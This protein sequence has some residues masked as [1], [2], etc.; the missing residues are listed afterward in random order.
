MRTLLI[1]PYF[2][3]PRIDA[4]DI[5]C[6]PMGLYQVAAALKARGHEVEVLNWHDRGGAQAAAERELREKRPQVV[7]CSILHANRWGGIEIAR[8]AK[9]IDP[10]VTVV[11]GGVGATFLWRH[12]LRHFPEIDYIV[13]GEGEESF[14]RLLAALGPNAGEDPGA[15][16]GLALRRRGRPVRTAAAEPVRDLDRLPMAARDFDLS[17]VA[18]TRGCASNC[19]FCGSPAVWGRRVRSHSAAYFVEQLARLRARG[20][21]F[22][23]V[24]DDTFT[25][26]RRR[27]LEV[28]RELAARRLELSWAAISRVDAVDEEVLGW[29][30]RAGCIQISYGVE[31]GSPQIRRRLNKRLRDAEIRTAF[32]WTQRYGIMARAYFI[33]GSPGETRETIQA[34]IDLMRAI[35]PLA[36][37]FYILDLF[38]G[39]ALYAAV[40]R[41]LGWTDDIWLRRVEDIPYFETDPS[42]PAE[43]VLEF[44]R[45]LRESFYRGLPGFVEALDPVADPEFRPLHADFFSR[46]ALTFDQGDYAGVDL[47]PG[48]PRLAEGLYRRAL[49]CHPHARAFLGLG[50]LEQRAGRFE[51]SAQTLAQGLAHFPQD[52]Q[53]MVCL[54][55]SLMNLNRFREALRLLQRCRGEPQVERLAAACR[56]ALR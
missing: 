45:M 38:P 1:Y 33:Y 55:V 11:F 40:K 2:I 14:P 15:I 25:L 22:V 31:S 4:E 53:L 18:L 10:A 3:D 39:T 51:P 47:I 20:R 12:L 43:R 48:K 44:G 35:K 34:S 26:N 13:L 21:R 42:L 36:C 32:E 8:M 29:M 6:V 23:Y 9:R 7:G 24:S 37:V 52:E 54:A 41:R 56:R 19:R 46:L 28:C 5:R 50:M 49:S 17:H 30:R 16:P 27:V